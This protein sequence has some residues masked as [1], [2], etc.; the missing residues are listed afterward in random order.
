MYHLKC[1][2]MHALCTARIKLSRGRSGIFLRGWGNLNEF[3]TAGWGP[4]ATEDAHH[5]SLLII[6]EQAAIFGKFY[7]S[8]IWH[9]IFSQPGQNVVNSTSFFLAG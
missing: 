6:V 3:S 7:G 1:V 5:R 9:I 4:E 8:L 2:C